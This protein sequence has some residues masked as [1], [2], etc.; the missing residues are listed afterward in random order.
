[1]RVG[2]GKWRPDLAAVVLQN[3]L[4][5]AKNAVPQGVGYGPFGSLQQIGAYGALGAY[6]RGAVNLNDNAGVPQNFAGDATKLYHIQSGAWADVSKG[7]GYSLGTKTR[8]ESTVYISNA[9]SRRPLVIFTC[10]DAPMQ[11]YEVGGSAIFADLAAAAPRAR[12]IAVIASHIIVGYTNDPADGTVPTRIWYPAIGNASSWPAPAS[13]TAVSAQS[14]NNVLFGD[15]G[16]IMGIVGGNLSGTIFQERCI[17]RADYV[18]QGIVFDVGKPV[19]S[20]GGLAVQGLAIPIPGGRVL[21]FNQDGWYIWD[22]SDAVGIGKDVVDVWFTGELQQDFSY[23]CSW[24]LDPDLPIVHIGFPGR[25][26]ISGQPNR[27]LHYNWK[28]QAFAYSDVLHDYLTLVVNPGPNLSMDRTPSPIPDTLTGS[29]DDVETASR[30]AGGFLTDH[31]IGSFAGPA[32]A[33]RFET[34]DL[35]LASGQRSLIGAVRPLVTGGT[36]RVSVAGLAKIN[37][38]RSFSTPTSVHDDGHCDARIDGRYHSIALDIDAGWTGQAVALDV[39]F[40]PTGWR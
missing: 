35:E 5:V 21:Y 2:L 34:G 6:A 28:T 4:R 37:G 32:L 15:F 18:G 30:V 11:A 22:G 27:I 38:T 19:T 24:V 20:G 8:W 12:H 39:D 26:S 33:A 16:D 40:I 17:R 36:A 9:T 14:G 3:D 23:R 1:V 7:G 10:L 25:G 29:W 31:T 13:T